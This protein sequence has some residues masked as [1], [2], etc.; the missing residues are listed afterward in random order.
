MGSQEDKD[1]RAL[2]YAG[3]DILKPVLKRDRRQHR[4]SVA[5]SFNTVLNLGFNSNSDERSFEG[6]FVLEPRPDCYKKVVV[7][8]GNSLDGSIMSE[9]RIF[10]NRCASSTTRVRLKHKLGVKL[11]SVLKRVEVGDA[12]EYDNGV[13]MRSA[14]MYIS[15]ERGGLTMLRVIIDELISDRKKAKR[16]GQT[17]RSWAYKLFLVNVCGA[18]GSKHGVIS[19]KTYV[20]G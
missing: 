11:D 3:E 18:I 7:I 9:L 8:D 10:S 5:V 20:Y 15:V 12:V 16:D 14:D 13:L 4:Q 6:G 2:F 1:V 17:D 19:S